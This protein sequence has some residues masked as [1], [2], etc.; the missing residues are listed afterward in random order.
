M[1][2]FRENSEHN[3]DQ[4]ASAPL[5]QQHY[6]DRN[7]RA[8]ETSTDAK[9]FGG[10]GRRAVTQSRTVKLERILK[11]SQQSQLNL[12]QN[13]CSAENGL[14]VFCLTL[15][16]S[17]CR[18]NPRREILWRRWRRRRRRRRLCTV[19]T[20]ACLMPYLFS[21]NPREALVS[22]KRRI[23]S[24]GAT[25]FLCFKCNKKLPEDGE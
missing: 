19:K 1:A 5:P 16:N 6:A 2:V 11:I 18:L 23:I 8:R 24:A 22:F 21:D 14:G 4:S 12:L 9:I 15:R 17:F 20:R 10:R 25:D 13:Q 7:G 3:L